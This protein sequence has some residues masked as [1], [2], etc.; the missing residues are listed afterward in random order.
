MAEITAKGKEASAKE[1]AAY[2]T[3]QIVNEMLARGIE[4][5][6]VDLYKSD[7]RKYLVEDGK[8]RLPFAS[9]SGVGESAAKSLQDSRKDGKYISVDDVQIRSK[10]TKAVIETLEEAGVLKSL[11]KTNQITFF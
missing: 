3:F 4:V 6:P 8:I 2:T 11:P 5:L 1:N 9:L 10:V 7:A